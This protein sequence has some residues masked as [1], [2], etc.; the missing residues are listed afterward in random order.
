MNENQ[1]LARWL[2]PTLKRFKVPLEPTIIFPTFRTSNEW[3]GVLLEKL[4]K[5]RVLL[6]AVKNG[7]PKWECDITLYPEGEIITG[8]G[9]DWR[10][11]V[12]EA[13]L[14]VARRDSSA[15]GD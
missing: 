6:D 11:A 1:Q 14:I 2:D 9:D 13:A 5:H 3:A 4:E 15:T 8:V 7:T 10:S 12:V